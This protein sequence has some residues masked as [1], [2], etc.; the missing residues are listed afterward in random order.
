MQ[1]IF[2][3]YNKVTKTYAKPVYFQRADAH[4]AMERNL[5]DLRRGKF[6][7][8]LGI[9]LDEDDFNIVRFSLVE[10]PEDLRSHE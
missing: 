6:S 7:S 8:S 1:T 10:S 3:I 4:Q 5:I 2:K 9:I